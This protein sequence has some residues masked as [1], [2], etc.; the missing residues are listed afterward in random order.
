M[1]AF[2]ISHYI[3][4]M[5]YRLCCQMLLLFMLWLPA[6]AQKTFDFNSA[7]RHAYKEIVQL[8]LESGQ[9]LLNTEKAQHPNNLVPYFLENY[10][11]FFTL[12]FNEDPAEYKK[13]ADRLDDRLDLMNEGPE[14]SPFYLYTKLVLHF[15]WA[16]IRIKF[17][18]RWDAGWEFRRSFLQAKDN[19]KSY[20]SFSPNL[21]Y[22]GAM[23]MVTA[24]I[25]DGYKWLSSLLGV[26][27]NMKTGMQR[28]T[29]FMN[30][31]DEW[32]QLFH[33]EA[34]FYYCYLQFYV[35]NDKKGIADFIEQ[36]HLDVVNNNLYTYLAANLSINNQQAAKAKKVLE[37]RN[38]S[39]GYLVTPVWDLEMGYTKL[40]HLEP[41]AGV[42]FESFIRNF[43]GKFYV[44]D[45]LLKLSWH[46]Y[47]QGDQTKADWYRRQIDK[48]GNTDTDADKLAQKE[49]KSTRWPNRLLLQARLLNDGGY[50]REA[51]RLLH[52]KLPSEFPLPEEKL[53][54][55]YR[56]GRL[57][58]DLGAD[59]AAINFYK[60]A[61]VLGENRK[62]YFAANA[63]LHIGF[64]CEERKDK[65]SAI[66]WFEKCISMEDH[67][68]KNSLDQKA[69]AGIGRCKE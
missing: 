44:K 16:A 66:A 68:F 42:Y 45:A 2:F 4:F 5:N 61:I 60:Q 29:Q 56:A 28:V 11:D 55:A 18:E 58:D 17:G 33:E 48:K 65:A 57:Y 38:Q 53:E 8:K 46:Y 35:N 37:E 26:K 51:L 19:L 52:G 32:A 10:I 3:A 23:Q 49:G 14:D 67:D 30:G 41:D 31:T 12:F 15:Q 69:K 59:S 6:V 63:A 13:C 20:P 34:V 24:T 62:E 36:Q 25:P 9:R 21:L 43:K 22:Y 64:I 39:A 27:G 47:L 50:H 7:C 1:N 40:H 54:F